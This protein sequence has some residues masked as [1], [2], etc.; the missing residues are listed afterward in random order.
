MFEKALELDP[1]YAEAYAFLVWTYGR[2]W[3]LQ[4]SQ[5]PQALERALVQA[6][7]AVALDDSLPLAHR[8]LSQVSLWNKQ[9][10]KAIA[11]AERAIALDPN[12]AESYAWLGAI[13]DLVGR[14]EEAIGLVE[15]A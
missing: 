9:H 7:Q 4:W 6:Q 10:A 5:D 3:G 13:L 1:Q 15:K 8:A 14:P 2:E 12:D 11:E